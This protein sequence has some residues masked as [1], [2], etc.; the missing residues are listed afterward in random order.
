MNSDKQEN[1]ICRYCAE[2][3]PEA[4]RLCP[5]CRQWLTF[6]SFRNPAVFFVTIALPV[7][8][9]MNLLVYTA[10]NFMN[11]PPYYSDSKDS[12]Q[13][14][15]SN[16]YW[17]ETSDG[18]FLFLTGI[19]TNRSHVAWKEPEFECRFFNAKGQMVDAANR[20]AYL[21]ILPDADSAFR[22][23]I[24]PALRSNDY[25]SFRMSI[26]NARNFRSIF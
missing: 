13:I 17:V 25:S 9:M 20:T 7:L 26:S 8:V 5:R 16:M 19:L 23:S 3:I 22:L 14:L 18:S 10:G 4:A 15:Q 24:K 6:R 1:K 21:T 12:I 2:N 11:Q